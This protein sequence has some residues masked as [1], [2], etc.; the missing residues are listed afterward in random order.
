MADEVTD[1][2][3]DFSDIDLDAV[4]APDTADTTSAT[5]PTSEKFT[6]KV[7]GQDVQ[8]TREELVNGYS[9]Q[10]DYTRKTQELAARQQELAVYE[11]IASALQ[12]DPV[13]TIKAL[14]EAYGF[15]DTREDTFVDP[16][17]QRVAQVES[18]IAQQQRA[19]QHRQIDGELARLRGS[20]GDFDEQALI[21]H[22]LQNGIPSLEAAYAHMNLPTLHSDAERLRQA[23]AAKQARLTAANDASVVSSGAGTQ[24]GVVGAAT[25]AKRMSLAEAFRLAQ[26]DDQ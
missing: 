15:E 5:E 26:A 23:R 10:A 13:A 12:T 17:E 6:V 24:A 21:R 8:V 14:Q 1:A 4:E 22:A 7:N 18:W 25:G 3:Q 11:R 20:Y 2:G 16:T 9:R 19:E